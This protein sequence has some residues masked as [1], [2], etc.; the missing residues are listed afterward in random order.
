MNKRG[1]GKGLG[2]LLSTEPQEQENTGE[3]VADI[4]HISVD[5]IETGSHQ[6]RRTFDEEKIAELAQSLKAHGV[7]QPLVVRD[8][9]NER[10]QLIVGERRWRA[11][12]AAGMETVPCILKISDDLEAAEL[13]LIENLQREDLSPID[14]AVA[15]RRMIDEYRYTQEALALGLGKSRSYIANSMRL[16]ALSEEAVE[17]LSSGCITAGHG[18]AILAVATE[19]GRAYLLHEIM[20]KELSVRQAEEL[21]KKINKAGEEGKRKEKP[22]PSPPAFVRQMEDKLR[23]QFG[24]KVK[25]KNTE[26]GG[27]IEIEYYSDE[28]LERILQHL[29]PEEEA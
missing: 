2:A 12:K 19:A 10:Y 29:I 15:F 5:A 3:Q 21:S 23:G 27:R 7:L 4:A 24:T 8:M 11:A 14:E 6:P 13:A 25:I 18:R 16:L 20:S 1:L 9:G 17:M 26:R 22:L 28:D